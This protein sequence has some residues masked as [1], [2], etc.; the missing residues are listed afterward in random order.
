MRPVR[1]KVGSW[2]LPAIA[3]AGTL[4]LLAVVARVSQLAEW[5]LG[6]AILIAAVARLVVLSRR[7]R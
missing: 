3:A 4:A 5:G 2:V 7:E 1:G 6:V